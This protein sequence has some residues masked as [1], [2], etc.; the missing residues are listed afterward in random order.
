MVN[1]A[2]PV[3]SKYSNGQL[4]QQPIRLPDP[5][6]LSAAGQTMLTHWEAT[7]VGFEA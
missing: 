4:Y 5:A 7:P 3:Q 1:D 2:S 6:A